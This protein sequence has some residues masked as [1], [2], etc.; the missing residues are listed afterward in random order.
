MAPRTAAEELLAGI[1]AEVLGIERVGV[2]AGF[3]EL[4]G[5]SLLAMRMVSRARQAFGVELPL[6]AL[7]EAPTVAEL[8]ARIE[9]L[10]SGGAARPR[11]HRAGAAGRPLPPSFA[12]QRLWLVDRL[13]PGSAAYNIPHALRLRGGLDAGALRASLD[14]LVRRHEALRTTFAERGG[15]PVQVIR[16]P[17]PVPL[18]LVDLRACRPRRGSGGARLAG[19]EALRPFDLAR[20]P[21]LRSTLLRLD[22]AEH[23]LLFTLHHVASD[24]WS[25]EVL[26]REVSAL[27]AAFRRGEPSPLPELPIQYADYA[28]WQ[29]GWLRG[30][31]LEAQLAYWRERLAGAP[32][33]LEVPTDRPRAAGQSARA[34]RHAF[35][36]PPSSPGA[37]GARAA[38]GGHAVHDASGGVA[39]AAGAL[40]GAGGRGGGHAGG[41][42]HPRGDG[43]ADR[44]LRQHAATSGRPVGRPHLAELLGR[45]REAALGAYSH[46]DLPFDRLVEEL[47]PER[48]LRTRRSSRPSSLCSAPRE[49][50]GW[51]W[52]RRSWSRSGPGRGHRQ[53][54]PGPGAGGRRRGAGGDAPLPGRAL[55]RGDGRADGGAPGDPAGGDGRRP[56]RRPSGGVAAARRRARAGA[57]GLERHRRRLPAGARVHELFAAQAART[58]DA[59]AVAGAG[60]APPTP[61]WTA[62]ARLA[63]RPAGR[64]VGPEARVGLC[65][66]RGPELRRGCSGLRAGGAY[67]PL[68]PDYPAERLAY[69]VGD[70]GIALVLTA[71]SCSPAPTGC[72]RCSRWTPRGARGAAAGPDGAPHCGAPR[73]PGVRHLH[74]G[75]HRPAQ[76]RDGPP[77][78][79]WCSCTGCAQVRTRSGAPAPPP[80]SPSTCRWRSSWPPLRGGAGVVEN[81]LELPEVAE[82][83]VTAG[84]VPTA[85]RE[86]LRAGGMPAASGR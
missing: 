35:A 74:L 5:H 24:G 6:R 43:G 64:G 27:Y 80:P 38:R 86:L 62:P 9:A 83:V 57:G 22:E 15:E 49:A 34:G 47:A 79:P 61:S 10:R 55:R 66:E 82:P 48:S 63:H 3:F 85:A 7:F 42:A 37:A 67:V 19:A 53:V 44:L 30:D 13:E 45:V 50:S 23:V 65:V 52:A 46:Q 26:V 25:I 73:E 68:D 16:P 18:P 69:M 54:R 75:L 14:E 39:A 40:G 36:L 17:A 51:R 33:L 21:L 28:V 78:W 2:E 31:T 70:S 29:R 20:G 60:G 1:W 8:A 81:A 56:A 32:P 59:V 11:R 77:P 41:G 76:G 84:V 4:G 58:P 12:Q 71:R 72:P